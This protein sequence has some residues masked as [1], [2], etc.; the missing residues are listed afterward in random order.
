MMARKRGMTC[1]RI[2]QGCGSTMITFVV[3]VFGVVW[4]LFIEQPKMLRFYFL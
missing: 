2:W 3:L 4:G 1:G